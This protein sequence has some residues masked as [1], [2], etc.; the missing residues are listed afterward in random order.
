MEHDSQ[1][2]VISMFDYI[3]SNIGE[4][5]FLLLLFVHAVD[6]FVEALREVTVKLGGEV[7]VLEQVLTK[8]CA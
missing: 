5:L 3:V 7:R 6:T 8:L 2:L 4:H 1:V